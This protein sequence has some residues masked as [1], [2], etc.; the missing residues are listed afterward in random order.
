MVIDKAVFG[1][2]IKQLYTS[3]RV[4]P[5][6]AQQQH[7]GN[8]R[9]VWRGSSKAHALCP[10]LMRSCTISSSSGSMQHAKSG[11]SASTHLACLHCVL[12]CVLQ[13]HK[14]DVWDD[15]N[16][17]AVMAGS[18]SEDLRY[19]K[20]VSLHLWLFGYEVTGERGGGLFAASGGGAL[21][22]VPSTPGAVCS[23]TSRSCMLMGGEKVRLLG[24]PRWVRHSLL[25]VRICV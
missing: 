15:I 3:W 25:S 18:A 13:E 12:H 5:A 21:T 20:S 11:S 14:G 16:V 17:L 7:A 8:C 19:L 23:H 24:L 4:R 22:L 6:A 2:R 1:R 9:A 10:A